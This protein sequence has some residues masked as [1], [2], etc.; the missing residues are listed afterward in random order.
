MGIEFELKKMRK[1]PCWKR[2]VKSKEQMSWL[3][4]HHD[5]WYTEECQHAKEL[6]R[7]AYF[8]AKNNGEDPSTGKPSKTAAEAKVDLPASPDTE[9]KKDVENWQKTLKDFRSRAVPRRSV[10]KK[11]KG[12]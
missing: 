7:E 10:E 5:R 8:T 12:G 9:R 4:K 3:K 11:K 2:L 6:W 1:E